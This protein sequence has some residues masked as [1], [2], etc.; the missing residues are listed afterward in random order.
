MARVNHNQRVLTELRNEGYIA[1]VVEKYDQFIGRTSDLFGF[2]DILAVGHGETL[3]IQVTSRGNMASRRRK[4]REAP[5]LPHLFA[6]GWHVELWGYD[7]PGGPRT[8]WRVK[9]EN[10]DG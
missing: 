1:S 8:A 5:E 6:A 3:A 10:L 4:I 2:I 7:Q 9:K